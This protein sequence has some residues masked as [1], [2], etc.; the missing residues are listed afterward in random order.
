MI[1]KNNALSFENSIE[2]N[3]ARTLITV[4]LPDLLHTCHGQLSIRKGEML[5]AGNEFLTSTTATR[6][7]LET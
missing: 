2:V 4:S 1:N 5:L 7:V 3:I 6:T